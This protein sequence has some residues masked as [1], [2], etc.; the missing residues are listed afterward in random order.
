MTRATTAETKP[1]QAEEVIARVEN[2]LTI[3][4]LQRETESKNLELKEAYEQIRIAQDQIARLSASSR[5][6][7]DTSAWATAMAAEVARSIGA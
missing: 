4:R 7:E 1:F 6:L 5:Q 2:Q 3:W